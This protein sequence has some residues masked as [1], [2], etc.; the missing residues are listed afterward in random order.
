MTRILVTNDDGVD[1]PGLRK[2]AGA[3]ERLGEV[4]VVAPDREQSATGH[5]LTLHRPLRMREH[6]PGVYSV[7]GTPTDCVNLAVLWLLRDNPPDL[8]VSGI[9]QGL[10]LGDDVTYSGTVSATFEGVL[11]RVPSVAFSQELE[12]GYSFARSAEIAALMI[13]SVLDRDLPDDFLL[14]VNLPAAPPRG[15][16]FTRLGYRVYEQVVVE[17]TDPRGQRYFWIAGSPQWRDE[18]GTDHGALKEG[19]VSVTPLH[20]DLTDYRRLS[21]DEALADRFAEAIGVPTDHAAE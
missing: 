20:L 13:E 9:N 18:H 19:Y 15:V 10:N 12:E 4:V 8:V 16:R 21:S 17:K 7:D 6:E 3:L 11:L 5:S 1:S 2:L 14:N